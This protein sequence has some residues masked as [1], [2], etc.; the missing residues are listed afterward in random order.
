M[1]EKFEVIEQKPKNG[2]K[3]ENNMGRK[4]IKLNNQWYNT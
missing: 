1:Q 4:R 2:V 3:I